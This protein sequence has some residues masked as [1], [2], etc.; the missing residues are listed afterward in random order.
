[1]TEIQ[2]DRYGE[3]ERD[4]EDTEGDRERGERKQH[5]YIG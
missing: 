4:R 1:M 2:N 3:T 5:V